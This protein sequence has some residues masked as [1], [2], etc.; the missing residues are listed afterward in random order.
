MATRRHYRKTFRK[1]FRKTSRKIKK[2][3]GRKT[4]RY[5]GGQSS[6]SPSFFSKV[7]NFLSSAKNKASQAASSFGN[8]ASSVG[9]SVGNVAS[10]LGSTVGNVAS[11]V[12]NVASSTASGL[13]HGVEGVTSRVN[14]LAG[15]QNGGGLNLKITNG[16]IGQAPSN[17]SIASNVTLGPVFSDPNIITNPLLRPNTTSPTAAPTT[18]APTTAAE[19]DKTKQIDAEFLDNKGKP[20]TEA[21]I[22][23]IA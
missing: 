14:N 8:V 2:K 21:M 20:L 16:V 4:K 3:R 17:S 7:G 19:D 5:V 13:Q 22:A 9:N 11:T 23:F 12:G 15:Y 6:D 1:T 10:S 18:A